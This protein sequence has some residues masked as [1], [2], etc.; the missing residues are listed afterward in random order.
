MASIAASEINFEAIFSSQKA[1]PI[2][3]SQMIGTACVEDEHQKKTMALK[4]SPKYGYL[5]RP[6]P[7]LE[8]WRCGRVVKAID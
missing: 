6:N 3:D 8:I 7:L 5:Y 4:E 2:F 1:M